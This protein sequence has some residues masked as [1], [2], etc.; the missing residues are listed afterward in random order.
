MLRNGV[1]ERHRNT[2]VWLVDCR[3]ADGQ[4]WEDSKFR[5]RNSFQ[6]NSQHCWPLS[7]LL[8]LFYRQVCMSAVCNC[9]TVQVTFTFPWLCRLWN[10]CVLAVSTNIVPVLA[11]SCFMYYCTTIL[12]YYCTTILIVV[13]VSTASTSIVPVLTYSGTM[14]PFSL[15]SVQCWQCVYSV[16][17]CSAS[18]GIQFLIFLVVVNVD[19]V[20]T[21]LTNVV[22]V[23]AYR[24]TMHSF[25]LNS[26]QWW[27]F[28][29]FW[30]TK[31]ANVCVLR[32]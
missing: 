32:T 26:G 17:Q 10:R 30:V 3:H 12:Y 2:G 16:D 21:A 8:T 27:C 19:S 23:L 1:E 22:P 29:Y 4:V 14:C 25:S 18:V 24:R 13:S 7:F 11:Y 20:S 6:V 31:L 9:Y 28:I 15:V 5:L